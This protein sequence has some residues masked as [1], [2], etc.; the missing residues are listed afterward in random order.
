M[1]TVLTFSSGLPH[2]PWAKGTV[3]S[4]MA[5]LGV[6]AAFMLHFA[7]PPSTESPAAVMID[8]SPEFEVSFVT[9]ELPPGVSQ[10]RRVE[11]MTLE[12]TVPDKEMPLLPVVEQAELKQ[13]ARQPVK[14]VEARKKSR[15]Q[16]Q[17]EKGNSTL[18]SR[19]APPVQTQ[20]SQRV[21]APIDTDSARINESKVT[22]ES[23]VKGKINRSRNYP[24]DARRR[25]R[26][27]TAM[28][29]FSV[30]SGGD[31]LSS[32][33]VNSSGT[34]SLDRAAIAAL[35]KAQPLPAPPKELLHNGVHKVTL[36][37]E[38]TL[39]QI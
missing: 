29:V 8:F 19:A 11:A 39:S 22:W 5:H 20:I 33:L 21:A 27:G 25:K 7:S 30:N 13:A 6:A 35:Q 16:Q 3:V 18:T 37:V 17:E 24:D 28:I 14:K 23:L 2:S 4:L 12:E 26:T 31:V 15:Q 1:K 38:F 10:Q 32:S 36:P 34:I 9:P